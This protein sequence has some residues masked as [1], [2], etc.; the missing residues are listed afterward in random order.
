[1]KNSNKNQL[2]DMLHEFIIMVV[3]GLGIALPVIIYN[4]STLLSNVNIAYVI[5]SAS[6]SA[7][8]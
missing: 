7:M 4:F 8:Y 5:D 6:F 2:K 3:F 1:M